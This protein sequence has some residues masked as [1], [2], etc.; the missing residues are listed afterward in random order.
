MPGRRPE[1][2]PLPSI[3][4]AVQAAQ[5]HRHAVTKAGPADFVVTYK[6]AAAGPLTPL[7]TVKEPC[8]GDAVDALERLRAGAGEA[9]PEQLRALQTVSWLYG[10]SSGWHP[11]VDPAREDELEKAYDMTLELAGQPGDTVCRRCGHPCQ[12]NPYCSHTGRR[13][14]DPPQDFGCYRRKI[15]LFAATSA[16]IDKAGEGVLVDVLR[17]GRGQ[18]EVSFA[19][20]CLTA[21]VDSA[22]SRAMDRAVVLHEAKVLLQCADALHEHELREAVCQRAVAAIA[23]LLTG[24]GRLAAAKV[25]IEPEVM[26]TTRQEVSA[27]FKRYPLNKELAKDACAALQALIWVDRDH[28]KDLKNQAFLQEDFPRCQVMQELWHGSVL[29]TPPKVC[30]LRPGADDSEWGE[31][32][33]C[34]LKEDSY[35][36]VSFDGA[37]RVEI[38][39]TFWKRFASPEWNDCLDDDVVK[40]TAACVKALAGPEGDQRPLR[41]AVLRLLSA[42][43][44]GPLRDVVVGELSE[45]VGGTVD[46][47][48]DGW[49]VL[50]D[51]YDRVD[52][53]EDGG[54]LSDLVGLRPGGILATRG[55]FVDSN[56]LV[57]KADGSYEAR[58]IQDMLLANRPRHRMSA[59]AMTPRPSRLA[60][61]AAETPISPAASTFDPQGGAWPDPWAAVLAGDMKG[62]LSPETEQNIRDTADR[63]E[64]ATCSGVSAALTEAAGRCRL[65]LD[66]VFQVSS[67]GVFDHADK[68]FAADLAA[69]VRTL[70]PAV[71]KLQ[72]ED[73][74]LVDVASPC[75]VFGDI[76]GNFGDLSD[77]LHQLCIFGQLRYTPFRLLFLGD[78]VDRGRWGP[79]V[80]AYILALKLLAPHDVVLLRGNHEDP[81]VNN[82]VH[83]YGEG[84]FLHQCQALW[85]AGQGK[86]LFDMVNDAFASMPLAAVIDEKIFCS[87]GGIPRYSGGHDDRIEVLRSPAFPCL[88]VVDPPRPYLNELELARRDGPVPV[89]SYETTSNRMLVYAY[90][91]LWADPSEEYETLDEY[92]FG[93]SSRD[94]AGTVVSYGQRA[95][96]EFLEH[97]GFELII[98]GH[99]ARDLGLQVSKQASV[100]TVFTS[101]DYCGSQT[102]GGVVLVRRAHNGDLICR[103]LRREKPEGRESAF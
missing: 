13:H 82:D 80:A 25:G 39:E 102:E 87:H 90:D 96:L 94:P 68:S 10:G 71:T 98:R 72:S 95:I 56:V 92:G 12:Q 35:V 78:Y 53:R 19:L 4:G 31:V 103:M 63:V 33:G 50:R 76:H 3:A 2:K 60:T 41:P 100:L 40:V 64:A 61:S 42:L 59:D 30:C 99:E 67:G 89:A 18:A 27:A 91:L 43:V 57:Q 24:P 47:K 83:R 6:P 45:K 75:F 65:F 28:V 84:S 1:R 49:C 38:S 52:Q 26:C 73:P 85:G 74:R 44:L 15:R 36:V 37:D 97:H 93:K 62:L 14:Y 11:V 29:T 8:Q 7:P 81:G 79:E 86:E 17:N 48:T 88:R 101:S 66:D 20:M 77:I 58:G 23:N 9:A 46:G 34:P 22:E 51:L 55:T 54:L 69:H 32:V 5:A 70:A 16:A 21:R